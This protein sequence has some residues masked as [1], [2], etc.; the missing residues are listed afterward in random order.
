MKTSYA[1]VIFIFTF[2]L[3]GN[4]INELGIYDID[5]IETGLDDGSISEITDQAQGSL[6]VNEDGIPEDDV[7]SLFA[8][9]QM[10][11][12]AAGV[13]LKAIWGTIVVY[14]TL[15]NMG[16]PGAIAIIG[17]AI[18]NLVEYNALMEFISGR[19]NVS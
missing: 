6:E 19:R 15:V 1:I 12:N 5:L 9:V 7:Y 13:I 18:T 14:P 4:A 2:S 3:M 8:G 17:Q 16:V 11:I 10:I